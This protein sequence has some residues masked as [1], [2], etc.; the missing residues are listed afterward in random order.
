MQNTPTLSEDQIRALIKKT[1]Q[2]SQ[3]QLV[4]PMASLILSD[5]RIISYF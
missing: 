3:E 5:S 4:S 1:V 2:N